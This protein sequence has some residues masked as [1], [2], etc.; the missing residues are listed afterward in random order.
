MTGKKPLLVLMLPACLL[1]AAQ[2]QHQVDFAKE[3]YPVFEKHCLVCHGP[4]MQQAKLR[5]DAR[6]IALGAGLG[7]PFVI[8]GDAARS[9]L[10]QRVAGIGSL[11]RMPPAGPK[12]SDEQIGVIRAWIDQG[13]DWPETVGVDVASP[14]R[15][16]A[17]VP[18]VRPVLPA[19]R[20]EAWVRNP[21]DR[22]ILARL[23]KDGLAPAPEASREKLIRRLSLD[24]TGL[25]PSLQDVDGFVADHGPDAY[26]KL[27]DRLLASPHYGERWAQYWLDLARYADTNGYES[28]EPRTMWAWRDWVIDAFNRNMP[29]DR[30]TIEQ[31]A[32]NLLPGAT[33]EQ[34]VATGFH[35]NTMVNNEAG[36]K[37]DEFRDAAVKDRVDTTATVWL[38]STLGCAQ[39]HNH[40]YDP[41]TQK[42]YYQLYA[43]FN[44]TA[45]S[46]IAVT[47]Q[48]K[49]FKGDRAEL[50][51]REAEM[52]PLRKVL[53]T[54]TPELEADQQ[55][56]EHEIRRR[57]PAYEQAWRL[58]EPAELRSA[59]G[60]T[61]KKLE[62]GSILASG[63]N[64]E[65]DTY[66]ID[67]PAGL[68][69][70][71][72]I[73]LEVL[74]HES[75]PKGAF[76][77][78]ETGNFILTGFEVESWA[79][80]QLDAHARWLE[81]KP[82]WGTWSVIGPFSAASLHDAYTRGFPP[83]QEV[84]LDRTYENGSLR[85]E[86]KA[87]W[88]DG[89]VENLEGRNCASYL[90]RSVEAPEATRV[91]VSLSSDHGYQ[92]WLNGKRI[93]AKNEERNAWL[94]RETLALDL[95]KGRNELLLKFH[96]GSGDYRYSFLPLEGIQPERLLS[97]SGA[98]ADR[99]EM[100]RGVEMALD[101]NRGTGWAIGGD[102]PKQ[103]Y[104][105][106]F[107]VATAQADDEIRL[108]IRLKQESS[109]KNHTIGRFRIWVTDLDDAALTELMSTPKAIREAL[110]IAPA[111][112]RRE[113]NEAVAAH[114]RSV[115]PL[116]EDVRAKYAALKKDYDTFV[117]KHS[118]TTLVMRELAEPRETHVQNRGNFL[119]PGERVEAAAPRVLPPIAGG[120]PP[121]RLALAR[122]LV[123]KDNPLTPRVV[124]NHF[125]RAI[126]GRG[127]VPTGE[128]FGSQGE[129]PSHPEL[130]DWLAVA[131][132]E[133]NWDVKAFLRTIVTSANYRQDSSVTPE[134]LSKDPDNKL[135]SR[136]PRFR[137][138]A[139]GVRDVALSVSGLLSRKIGGPSVF[140]PQAVNIFD[141]L[142]IEDGLQAWPTSEG[143]DRYRRGLYTFYKRASPYPTYTTFDAPER[144][145]CTVQR[146]RSNTPLQALTTLNDP[147]FVEAAGRLA[148]R[149][150][151]EASGGPRKSAV[152]GF[153]LATTRRPTERELAGLLAAY[154]TSAARYRTDPDEARKLVAASFPQPPSGVDP[155]DLAPLIVVSNV[156]LNLD[157]TLTRE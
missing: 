44:N 39:C 114:Y 115:S 27:V 59:G 47:E 91:Y 30:F 11:L 135:L 19:V 24:L 82:Q 38:G 130:L 43:F 21:I 67:A 137:V 93:A 33:E 14:K 108:R 146:P 23:E 32:G 99:A 106:I 123:G 85:W 141:D 117:E 144:N 103:P 143:E 153:R 150:L 97:V 154:E 51:R 104:Q 40:K 145:V 133:R 18:P 20:N 26:E 88:K 58:L 101:G 49:V 81:H 122:W 112:R 140:P 50:A 79:K 132:R 110:G 78:S 121:N 63:Q 31:I 136:A 89:S 2:A 138:A 46:G 41:F 5:L 129:P 124:A 152:H 13:A 92:L 83:E 151:A 72:G 73:K 16:W 22:F 155:G 62:D 35:R 120:E 84:A 65:R 53:D 86:Q 3:V 98:V 36:A 66:E 134:K 76:S 77:R 80:S 55:Q 57:L 87:R 90:Y 8:P 54:P 125:W 64:S 128:D 52:A 69:K 61:F 70:I 68:R 118:T 105:A 109:Q 75:L 149:L 1:S 142:F 147:V 56:W 157:E 45:E 156:L 116:L 100:D 96:N 6:L 126:F 71:T 34:K 148:L 74:P 102:A 107:R 4:K 119:N 139:E 48:M 60:A 131:L 111:E 15:H 42:D 12:L 25:P 95:P 9:A 28:D 7:G 17:Y 127:I 113:Q 10:Y 37:D 94:D 29:F